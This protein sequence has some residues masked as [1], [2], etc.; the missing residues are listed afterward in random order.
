M[1]NRPCLK[2]KWE[3]VHKIDQDAGVIRVKVPKDLAGPYQHHKKDLKRKAAED[4]LNI[5]EDYRHD[6][7]EN[8]VKTR[9]K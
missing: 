3:A 7:E 4:V 5:V 1:S 2:K 9:K 8:T 6:D